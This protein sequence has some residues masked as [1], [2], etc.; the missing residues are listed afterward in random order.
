MLLCRRKRILL[1]LEEEGR[2]RIACRKKN[3]S[4]VSM[5]LTRPSL[6]FY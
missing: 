2:G 5:M 3:F 6:R 4:V 1:W